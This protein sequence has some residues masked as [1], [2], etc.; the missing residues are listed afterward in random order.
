M[1]CWFS[2]LPADVLKSR[3]QIGNSLK[4]S[5]VFACVYVSNVF[6]SMASPKVFLFERSS[7]V[8]L[9]V[10]GYVPAFF[11]AHLEDRQHSQP[12]SQ[13]TGLTFFVSN[14]VMLFPQ[15]L[16]FFVVLALS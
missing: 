5:Y 15:Y 14:L 16:S 2:I 13:S 11:C 10:R 1:I 7:S 6:V 9:L 4:H 12:C 8:R 3:V